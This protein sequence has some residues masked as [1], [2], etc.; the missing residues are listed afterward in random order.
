MT[1]PASPG[2]FEEL[3]ASLDWLAEFAGTGRR[4]DM[5]VSVAAIKRDAEA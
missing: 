4:R 5:A 1:V 2:L 3:S